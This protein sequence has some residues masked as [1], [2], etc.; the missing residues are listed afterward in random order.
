[1]AWFKWPSRTLSW[2]M[3]S[4]TY[5]FNYSWMVLLRQSNFG[6][7]SHIS[8]LTKSISLLRMINSREEPA[9]SFWCRQERA[10]WIDMSRA[11]GNINPKKLASS[12]RS[13]LH[14]E[15]LRGCH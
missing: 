2:C 3:V 6:S 9:G 8:Y 4:S 5:L 13:C 7:A 11:F 10:K 15:G 14:N 1:M 12:K